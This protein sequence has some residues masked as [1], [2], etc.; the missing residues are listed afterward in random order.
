MVLFNKEDKILSNIA[1]VVE[2]RMKTADDITL[3]LDS[4]LGENTGKIWDKNISAGSY[5]MLW[6]AI[7][8][9]LRNPKIDNQTFESYKEFSGMY[10]TTHHQNFFDAAPLEVIYSYIEDSA[11]WGAEVFHV[12]YDIHHFR[13]IDDPYA[14]E[15]GGRLVSMLKYVKS[16]GLKTYLAGPANEAFDSSPEE[17][18]ADW[19][20]GHDGYIHTL[21]SHYHREICPNKPG[22]I[23][24]MIEYRRQVMEMFKDVELDYVGFGPYDEGG[25]TCSKCRPWGSNG[26]IKCLEA[27]IP[28]VKEYQ[29]NAKIIMGLWLFD[30]FTEDC[31]SAG[32]QML[33][34]EGRLSEVT[35]INPMHGSYGY[36]HEMYRPKINFTEISM[37]DTAPWGGYGANPI[38]QRFQ[39]VWE[40]HREFEVGGEPY[41]EGIYA[42]LNAVIML[43]CYRA[44]QNAEDTVK[45]YLSYEFGLEGNLR[46]EV[47]KAIY[48]MGETLF[49][50]LDP[51]AH[52]YPIFESEKVFEIEETFKKAHATLPEDVRES[53]KWQ[54]LYLRAMID[55]ELKRND[56][57]RNET[58]RA[59][60]RKIIKLSHLEKSDPWTLPDAEDTP[61]GW[62]GVPD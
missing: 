48:G 4:N 56:Y 5:G 40:E 10:F 19:T 21:N 45:E 50:E 3:A 54:L 44:N 11:L 30:H 42:D 16:L 49:R 25:C 7:G 2:Q 59:Y 6:E 34:R 57:Y 37:T 52:R 12:W 43:R 1:R 51:V 29:P 28:V 58:V 26:Y 61:H 13:D 41:H 24:K 62:I 15:I 17:L 35:Y 18:R 8:R 27:L 46:D 36:T 9:Y 38:P 53:V 22:G 14:H 31:E 33:L 39:K 55:G 23:E 32:V 47:C 20:R 60:F